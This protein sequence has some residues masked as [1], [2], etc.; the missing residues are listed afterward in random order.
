MERIPYG[1]QN[2]KSLYQRL[3]LVGLAQKLGWT[4]RQLVGRNLLTESNKKE[5]F[6][7]TDSEQLF[8]NYAR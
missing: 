2:N 7:K 5:T 1:L 3:H 8:H 4:S 6:L